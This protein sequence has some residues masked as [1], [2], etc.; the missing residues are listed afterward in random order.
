MSD[1]TVAFR[2]VIAALLLIAQLVVVGL[3][4]GKWA[5][6]TT[7]RLHLDRR[8]GGSESSA[9]QIFEIEAQ[10]VVPE[11]VSHKAHRIA[12]VSHV[13]RDSVVQ[14][15]IRSADRTAYTI[16]SRDG[17]AERVLAAG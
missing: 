3:I 7:Y 14:A 5:Y 15:E 8:V 13:D 9:A 6:V 1:A 11:I 16:S 4:L 17:A 2:K 12:F 10:R